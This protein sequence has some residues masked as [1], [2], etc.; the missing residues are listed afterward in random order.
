[1]ADFLLIGAGFSR[2]WGGW[3]ATEAFE[4]LLGSTEVARDPGLRR[5]LWQ[6]QERGGFEAA[7]AELQGQ[8]AREP[9]AV[10]APLIALQGAVKRMFDD[11]NAAFMAATDW[12][13]G[14]Q[15]IERQIGTFLT[16]FDAIFTLNQDVLLEHHYA[17]DNIALIGKK[18]WNGPELPGMRRTPPQEALYANSWSRSTWTP[19]PEEDFKADGRSQPIY[20]LHG[21][22]NWTRADGQPLLI[23]GG[24]K[25]REI[26]HTPILNWY[27]KVFEESLVAGNARLMAIGYGFRDEHINAAIARGVERGLKLFIVA[28]EGAELARR[29]NPTRAP[30]QITAPTPLEGLVEES[31][32]GASR[33]GLREIFGHDDAEFAKLMRFFAA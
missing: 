16:R 32:I 7:L 24:A 27:A 11:M 14:Q 33:R 21:S 15:H 10:R 8:F 1:M 20:K 13:F 17:N 5:L 31:L 3:L 6:H 19:A 28:P 18:K 29:L 12:Q 22:S 4:H 23:M 26:G 9:E 30:G 2:N 25:A